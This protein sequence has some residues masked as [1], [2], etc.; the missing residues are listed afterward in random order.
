MLCGNSFLLPSSSSFLPMHSC[1]TQT[2]GIQTNIKS[3]HDIWTKQ[4]FMMNGTMCLFPSNANVSFSCLQTILAMLYETRSRHTQQFV[5]ATDFCL[6]SLS[7]NRHCKSRALWNQKTF[8][9]SWGARR[10]HCYSGNQNAM[11]NMFCLLLVFVFV[12]VACGGRN[13]P[14]FNQKNYL[15]TAALAYLVSLI[16]SLHSFWWHIRRQ[17]YHRTI[18]AMDFSSV[19]VL[20]LEGHIFFHV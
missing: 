9:C 8:H 4:V 18:H 15:E 1:A 16:S 2:N 5:D 20:F 17:E 11:Q 12:D 14:T 13:V 6:L 10:G 3:V 19:G 7:R